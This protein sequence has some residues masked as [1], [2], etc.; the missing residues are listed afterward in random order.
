M[1][2]LL[3]CLRFIRHKR[4]RTWQYVLSEWSND[5]VAFEVTTRPIVIKISKTVLVVEDTSGGEGSTKK[6]SVLLLRDSRCERENRIL[7]ILKIFIYLHRLRIAG[8]YKS[9]NICMWSIFV[10]IVKV[11]YVTQINIAHIT[12]ENS[13]GLHLHK[14][15]ACLACTVWLHKFFNEW[16]KKNVRSKNKS[17]LLIKSEQLLSSN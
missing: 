6:D 7:F 14:A 17:D 11:I 1:L 9:I 15:A 4:K 8:S 5:D 12:V 3:K 2:T 10:A 16:L 13:S